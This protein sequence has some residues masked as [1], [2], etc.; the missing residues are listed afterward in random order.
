[1]DIR[2]KLEIVEQSV[3]SISRHD[4]EDM[5]VRSAALDRVDAFIAAERAKMK[6]RVDE[7]IAASIAKAQPK[8]G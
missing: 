7:R 4:D 6:E 3:A 2:R 8:K 1:M 5:A